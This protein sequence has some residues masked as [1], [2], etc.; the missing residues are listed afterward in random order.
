MTRK[1]RR[2]AERSERKAQNRPP[3][4]QG[5][6]GFQN[7]DLGS[8][9][10]EEHPEFSK[11]GTPP[12]PNPKALKSILK[13]APEESR[14]GTETELSP[15]VQSHVSRAAKD[16]IKENDAEI[17]ALEKKLGL[18]G[19]KISNP[20]KDGLDD[21][22]GDLDA[23]YGEDDGE[24]K[25]P[26]KRKRADA[27]DEWLANKRQR[28]LSVPVAISSEEDSDGQSFDKEA[29][30]QGSKHEDENS[31]GGNDSDSFEM[32]KYQDREDQ[33]IQPYLRENPYI[34]PVIAGTSRPT[35]YVPPALRV[36]LSSDT[37]ALARLKRQIQGLLNRLSDANMLTILRDIEQVY[38]SN[39]RG[40]VNST[41]IDLL[42]G[43]LADESALP[44]TFL[45]LHAGFIAAVYKVIG[46]D[47]GAQIVERIVNEVDQHY[48]K[49]SS[50]SG[51][52]TTNLV[53]LMAVLYIFQ[54]IGSNLVFDY[55]KRF[56]GQLSEV[57]TELLLRIVRISG[58][59]L[60]QD[61][62]TALKDI[63]LLL[64]KL[65][66][67]VG[68]S[69]LPVRTK[70]MIETINYLKNNRMKTGVAA[71]AVVSEHTVRMKK[72]LGSLNSR[73]L[74]GTEPLRIGLADIKNTEKKG[75]WWLVGASW[76]DDTIANGINERE[77]NMQASVLT[78][79]EYRD[80]REVD[81]LQLAKE[82]RMNTDIRR[83]IFISIMSATDFRDAHVRLL[84][85]NLKKSQE[86]EIPRVIVHCAGCEANYNPFYTLLAQKSCSNHKLRKCFQF[87]LWDVF[88]SLGER[89]DEGGGS[90]D[91]EGT[92]NE[93]LSLRK[94]V[95]LGKLYGTLIAK[96]GLSITSLK[97][98][99][100][101][102]LK[103]KTKTFIEIM[104]VT[105]LLESQKGAK[106]GKGEKRLLNVFI[107]ADAAL[108][109][110]PGLQYFFKKVISRTNITANK[111]E[112]ETVWWACTVVG[113]MLA[114][115]MATRSMVED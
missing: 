109:M 82:Q 69:N 59:Q 85:L 2:K 67:T 61:D 102:Y 88:K 48:P 77:M 83:A 71:S 16:R 100:F 63:V 56:L 6:N 4:P 46:T 40:Y 33:A 1:D 60:R 91:S 74:K 106:E 113:D 20:A 43:L 90:D 93:D 10:E 25:V 87:A 97:P 115:L 27:D 7:T 107:N 114:R 52:Q 62:P 15:P 38:Q 9:L 13:K 94:L 30:V 12:P 95:N 81:L 19:K 89:K 36:P 5:R 57:N 76:R 84:K 65:V 55:I 17:R 54:V 24:E 98:L 96:D 37:E 47:F 21:I 53:S 73:N 68:E 72:Q 75:K 44:D 35:R 111:V 34:A 14:P 29:F 39:P 51:K 101:P 45:I 32:D 103:T 99:N 104:L 8:D 80:D 26:A 105:I 23:M 58:A 42:V 86:I 18:K 28:A 41:L 92:T 79:R 70:F 49:K 50:G 64:Q 112:K 78:G 108:E 3:Q 31:L 110:V 11:E 66:S 22:F